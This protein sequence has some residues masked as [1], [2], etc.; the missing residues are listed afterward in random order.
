MAKPPATSGAEHADGDLA[1]D[2]ARALENDEFFLVYQPTIDLQ[3]NAFAGVEALIRWRHPQRGVVSPLLFLNEL[4]AS[5][6]IVPVGPSA[7]RARK[8]PPGTTGATGS[9]S[10]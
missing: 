1:A 4:E 8:A 7:S 3:T 5:G 9:S 2:L 10:P 6:L